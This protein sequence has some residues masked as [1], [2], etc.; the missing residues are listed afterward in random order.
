[1]FEPLQIPSV[2]NPVFNLDLAIVIPL[3]CLALI[4]RLYG[5][6]HGRQV[7]HRIGTVSEEREFTHIIKN[8]PGSDA[9]LRQVNEVD[10][11]RFRFAALDTSVDALILF[12]TAVSVSHDLLAIP[13]LPFECLMEL[14]SSGNPYITITFD[15]QRQLGVVLKEERSWD[16][17]ESRFETESVEDFC[18]EYDFIE[19]LLLEITNEVGVSLIG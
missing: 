2:Y 19:E 15:E 4:G 18:G 5:M 9:F 10:C 7:V 16:N 14:N 13:R 1:M 11:L 6:A 12:L 17:L 3:P 8:Y